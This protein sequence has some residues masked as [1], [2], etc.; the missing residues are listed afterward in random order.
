MTLSNYNLIAYLKDS[1]KRPEVF[2][3]LLQC[4]LSQIKKIYLQYDNL[5]RLCEQLLNKQLRNGF[6]QPSKHLRKNKFK[7]RR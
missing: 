7:K 5:M 1:N 3:R 4:Q 2:E 6:R